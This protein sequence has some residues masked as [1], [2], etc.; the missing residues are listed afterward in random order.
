MAK[1]SHSKRQA[2]N[3][4]FLNNHSLPRKWDWRDRNVVT[5]VRNQG[6]CGACWAHSTVATIE[7]MVAIRTGRLIPFSVQQL[8]DC[9]HEDD[10]QAC[11]GGD[12][13]SALIWMIKNNVTLERMADYP[14]RLM[15]GKC[16]M[17]NDTIK[18]GV[19]IATNYTCDSFV[20]KEGEM[21]KLLAQHGPLIAA[22]D[23]SSWQHY[24]GGVIRYHCFNDLNHAVQITGYD[25]T[26]K[27]VRCF[28]FSTLYSRILFFS[29]PVPGPVPH[30]IVRNTWDTGF[31]IDGYVH[32][33]IGNNVC[34]VAEE[35]SAVDVVKESIPDSFYKQKL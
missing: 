6:K 5:P 16:E 10:N 19:R 8:V 7:S 2:P 18:L 23:S 1:K 11:F 33:A 25:L 22:V 15:S 34:G 20:G 35:I 21:I 27:L 4:D 12:T 32:L 3:Q 28:Y 24:L 30:Y 14:N 26:G 13:C 31:G 9:S 17:D 29:L